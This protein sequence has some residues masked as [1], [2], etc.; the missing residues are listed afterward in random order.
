MVLEVD[1]N[2]TLIQLF[3][4]QGYAFV[5]ATCEK[6]HRAHNSGFTDGCEA[7][8]SGKDCA[9]P[10]VGGNFPLYEGPL[11]KEALATMCFR[12]GKEADIAVQP[13]TGGQMIGACKAHYEHIRP[14][15]G[16]ALKVKRLAGIR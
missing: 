16:K 5:C 4:A 10:I 11:T 9:G 1:V 8:L 14:Q 15:S 2:Q 13:K 6:L 3:M 12:C 7:A